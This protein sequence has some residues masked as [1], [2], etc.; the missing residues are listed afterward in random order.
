[1]PT[2]PRTRVPAPLAAAPRFGLL[3]SIPTTND[4]AR[5]ETGIT[6]VPEGC[7]SGENFGEFCEVPQEITDGTTPDAVE[8][9]PYVLSVNE[10]CSTF[11]GPMDY[12][13]GRVER[14]LNQDTERQL[15]AELWDGT[16]AQSTTPVLANTWLADDSDPNFVQLDNGAVDPLDA[17][18]CLEQYLASNNGGQQGVIHATVQTAAYWE[19]L[20]LVYKS[21]AKCYTYKDTL[22]VTSPGYTGNSPDGITSTGNVWA[23][24]TDLPRIFLGGVQMYDRPI[25]AVDRSQNTVQIVAQR[26]ALVEW[27]RCRHAGIQINISPCGSY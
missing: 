13:T 10:L 23:Y 17:L 24:A 2:G 3:A 25:Q 8:W 18:A 14:L 1:M 7:A 11:S 20:R 6:Y 26:F 12:L 19:S 22:V 27:Q 15:G 16:V 9:D 4:I 5:W 21:G